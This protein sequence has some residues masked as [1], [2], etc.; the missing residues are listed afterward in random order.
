MSNKTITGSRLIVFDMD[1]VVT[2]EVGYWNAAR[3]SVG[4]ILLSNRFFG[5]EKLRLSPAPLLAQWEPLLSRDVVFTLSQRCVNTNWDRAFVALGLQL[6]GATERDAALFDVANWVVR[7][8]FN[9][10]DLVGA[11]G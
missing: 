4:E 2:S 1:G 9:R 11:A 3:L 10:S 8:A 6:L 7:E 5:G